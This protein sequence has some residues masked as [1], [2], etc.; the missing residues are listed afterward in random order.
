MGFAPTMGMGCL[1]ERDKEKLYQIKWKLY[2]KS[3]FGFDIMNLSIRKEC[4]DYDRR[5]KNACGKAV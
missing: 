4:I 2:W 3:F 1:L 5:A